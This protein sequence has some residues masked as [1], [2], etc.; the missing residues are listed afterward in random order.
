MSEVTTGFANLFSVDRTGIPKD[1]FGR[2][3]G[4]DANLGKWNVAKANTLDKMFYKAYKFT[5]VGLEK[6]KTTS[7]TS[8]VGAFNG[9]TR[10]NANVAGTSLCMCMWGGVCA[11]VCECRCTCVGVSVLCMS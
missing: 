3:T 7:V 6:W 2:S 4:E 8:L 10:M 5:G 11:W 1:R 9:A